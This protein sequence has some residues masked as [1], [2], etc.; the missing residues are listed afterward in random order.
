MGRRNLRPVNAGLVLIW[1]VAGGPFWPI[2]PI[3]LWGLA[4]IG[5]AVKTFN[6]DYGD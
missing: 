6:T 4:L 5:N 3:V 2:W 1:I